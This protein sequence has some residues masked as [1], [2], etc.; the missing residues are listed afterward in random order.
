MSTTRPLWTRGLRLYDV[1][2]DVTANAGVPAR[3][4]FQSVEDPERFAMY[5]VHE[6]IAT[7]RPAPFGAPGATPFVA[8][9]PAAFKVG[10]DEHTLMVVREFRRVPLEASAL[11]LAVF[12]ARA[13]RAAS[14]V[15]AL[16]HFAER[17]VSAYQPA[18]LL[19]AHSLERPR[20]VVLITGVHE[21]AALMAMKP[22]AFS[23]DMLLPEI[24]PFLATG[25]EWYAYRPEADVVACGGAVSPHAV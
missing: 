2:R 8:A 1:A 12:T 19:L 5:F 10:G 9:A 23:I 25:P 6:G 16:A 24:Q 17:A 7:A 22:S 4:R 21:R 3:S 15:A 18:Y 11:A 13:G 14:L 20:T